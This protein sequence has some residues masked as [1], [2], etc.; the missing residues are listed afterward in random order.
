MPR[1]CTTPAT[2]PPAASSHLRQ[3]LVFR[4]RLIFGAVQP[5]CSLA[6]RV[7]LEQMAATQ[8]RSDRTVI[9]QLER[10][11]FRW[12][13]MDWQEHLALTCY[14]SVACVSGRTHQRPQGSM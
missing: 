14:Q 9:A 1:L 12:L 10:H 13:A 8:C 5:E 6:P 2:S 11:G 3:E 4:S 7:T